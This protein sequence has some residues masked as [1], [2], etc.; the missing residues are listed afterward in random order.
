MSAEPIPGGYN[1]KVLR[2]NLS[3]NTIVTEEIDGPFCRKYLGGAGFVAYYLLKELKSHIDPLGPDNKLVFATGPL[4]GIKLSGSAR[5]CVGAKSPL[6]NTIAKAEAGEF[7]G[8]ELK[9]AGFDALIVEGK[10]ARP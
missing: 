2:V 6:S 4:T 5:H 3:N 9:Y 8:V 1:G 7:W 10:A